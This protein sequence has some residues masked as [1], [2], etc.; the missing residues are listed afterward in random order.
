MALSTNTITISVGI[1]VVVLF[2]LATV[3]FWTTN[4]SAKMNMTNYAALVSSVG[5]IFVFI[6]FIYQQSGFARQEEARTIDRYLQLTSSGWI[7]VEKEVIANYPYLERWYSQIYPGIPINLPYVKDT[8]K[9]RDM[10]IHISQILIQNIENIFIANG[11][12]SI[13]WATQQTEWYNTFKSW[14]SS[15]IMQEVW[16]YVKPFFSHEMQVFIDKQIL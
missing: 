9:Q 4:H 2:L 16:S 7:D 13:T 11:G 1:V 15:P 8:I 5:I 14:M 6:T 12:L 3:V 10:E